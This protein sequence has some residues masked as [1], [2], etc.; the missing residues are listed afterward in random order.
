MASPDYS[1]KARAYEQTFKQKVV[2][3]RHLCAKRSKRGSKNVCAL[4]ANGGGYVWGFIHGFQKSCSCLRPDKFGPI[5]RY[6]VNK[7]QRGSPAFWSNRPQKPARHTVLR[8]DEP[9]KNQLGAFP[10]NPST[11]PSSVP[12]TKQGT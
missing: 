6:T 5:R 9:D 10:T 2:E 12:S 11:P 1:G 8:E 3:Y 7:S 4:K